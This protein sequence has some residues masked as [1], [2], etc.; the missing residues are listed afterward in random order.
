MFIR[1]WRIADA[2][3]SIDKCALLPPELVIH[4]DGRAIWQAI[5]CRRSARTLGVS[6]AA[7]AR[8]HYATARPLS[9][10]RQH[11]PRAALVTADVPCS[12][13]VL[14]RWSMILCL[15][16]SGIAPS[17][18]PSPRVRAEARAELTDPHHANRP[19]YMT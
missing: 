2:C 4:I 19:F 12:S 14:K 10:A 15:L 18:V 8:A 17:K 9:V 3:Q 1:T 6:A 16:D 13:D 11:A 7:R 5:S